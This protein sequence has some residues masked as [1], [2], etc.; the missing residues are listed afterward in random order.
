MKP[1]GLNDLLIVCLSYM[2]NCTCVTSSYERPKTR[3]RCHVIKATSVAWK[4]VSAGYR[5][6]TSAVARRSV[7]SE[8]STL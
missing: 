1:I 7:C 4:V 5:S 6:K 8:R 2:C 3:I